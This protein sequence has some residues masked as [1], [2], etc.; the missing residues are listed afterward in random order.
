MDGRYNDS[1]RIKLPKFLEPMEIPAPEKTKRSKKRHSLTADKSLKRNDGTPQQVYKSTGSLP[2]CCSETKCQCDP[3]Q[4]DDCLS[5][6]DRRLYCLD[7]Q[8][9]YQVTE[10]KDLPENITDHGCLH[11]DEHEVTAGG[12]EVVGVH[13]GQK[14]VDELEGL[15]K[16][17]QITN[18]RLAKAGLSFEVQNEPVMEVPVRVTPL[19]KYIVPSY[20][21]AIRKVTAEELDIKL[22]RAEIRRKERMAE[23]LAHCKNVVGKWKKRTEQVQKI[24]QERYENGLVRIEQRMSMATERRNQMHVRNNERCRKRN[25]KIAELLVKRRNTE[26]QLTGIQNQNPI[27]TFADCNKGETGLF[28]SFKKLSPIISEGDQAGD[29]LKHSR[30]ASEREQLETGCTLSP[31]SAA[32]DGRE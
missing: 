26:K 14:I 31:L 18:F 11:I 3:G 4:L 2:N 22:K 27:R 25:A 13:Y 21:R 29:Q 9:P 8:D 19:A 10:V 20:G 6:M 23:R 17:G 1:K 28:P 24:D 30:S 5:E 32:G 15:K 7:Y 16:S 12:F